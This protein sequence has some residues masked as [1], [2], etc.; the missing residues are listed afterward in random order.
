MT[1]FYDEQWAKRFFKHEEQQLRN[2]WPGSFAKAY[3]EDIMNDEKKDQINPAHYQD[4]VPGMQYMEMMVHMLARFEG[5][6]AH[7]MGQVYKYLMR[8][9]LKDPLLQDLKKA[10]WYLNALV[11]EV[12]TGKVM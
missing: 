7:L 12:E 6:E 4:V 9:K 5:V 8:A 1:D 2:M 11:K 10:Q 3:N